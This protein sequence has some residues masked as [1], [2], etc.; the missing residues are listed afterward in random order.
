MRV[1]KENVRLVSHLPQSYSP[2]E[3]KKCIQNVD[4]F[5]SPAS[6]LSVEGRGG[7][8]THVHNNLLILK[9][10]WLSRHARAACANFV[11]SSV[12]CSLSRT[13]IL[14]TTCCMLKVMIK[15]KKKKTQEPH[16][17]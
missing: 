17:A 1:F 7:D 15:K 16:S 12:A 2:V 14:M 8:N 11:T 6:L 10:P 9:L 3:K 5:I 13:C 4:L